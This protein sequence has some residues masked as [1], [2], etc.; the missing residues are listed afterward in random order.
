MTTGNQPRF[1]LDVLRQSVGEKV[2]ARGVAYHR[3][4]Q[5]EIL[6]VDPNRV[7][8]QVAGSEDYRVE[9]TGHG[10]TY[11][12]G[13]SCRA[14]ADWGYCKHLV[15]TAIAAND[16]PP[17]A[18]D[19][20]G[21]LGRIRDHLTKQ[22]VDALAD[23]VLDLATKDPALFCKLDAAAAVV[24]D[25][26]NTLRVRLRKAIDKATRTNGYVD[27]R[28]A[29]NWASE[30]QNVLETIAPLAS[31]PRAGLAAE[32]AEH[33]FDR[34][35]LAS[36]AIDDSDGHC[37]E[38]LTEAHDIHV[39]AIL[40]ARPEPVQLARRLL[41][42]EMRDDYGSFDIASESYAEALGE[43]GLAEYRRLAL[44]AWE[45]LPPRG[46]GRAQ[47]KG[48]H[49]RDHL[50]RILDSFAECDGDVETRIAL[51]AAD[52]S[53]QWRY[54]QLAEFCRSQGRQDEAL[55][56]A[57]EGLWLF[58]DEPQD[59][60]L[61]LFAVDLLSKAGREPE[62]IAHLRRLFE[63]APSLDLY[64]RLGKHGGE[65]ACDRAR[66][67]L[68]NALASEGRTNRHGVGDLLTRI[69]MQEKHLDAAWAVIQKHGASIDVE[70]D[71][72]R[73][74]EATHPARAIEAYTACVDEFVNSGTA[75]A[76]ENAAKLV[77]RMAKLRRSADQLAY[78]DALKLRFVRRRNFVKLLG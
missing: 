42:R 48:S 3:D 65:D 74:G 36:Q 11:G 47:E 24:H 43:A 17:G 55:R 16:L 73:A 66:T 2:F 58:E 39:A 69:H 45:K 5:V 49:K 22:G 56:R 31:G 28:K 76:Y 68:E 1:D 20:A 12:G 75:S 40:E 6:L 64:E 52:L 23:L 27:Y 18:T 32:L 53:S 54:L 44:L 29:S 9:I 4:G 72:A 38:L 46:K 51:R 8:A 14:F 33:A 63:K 35:M 60:R 71:L 21:A 62:A 26:E 19:R 70:E 77:K 25:D 30:V 59:Q 67:F 61:V 7:L 34:I 37:G 41:A 57:E 50:A 10:K 13:C 15:A 78:V